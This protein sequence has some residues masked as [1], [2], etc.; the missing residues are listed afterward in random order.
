MNAILRFSAL[1]DIAAILPVL[2]AL[3]KKPIIITSPLGKEL[4]KDEFDRFI[5]LRSKS[6]I[7]LV[8]LILEIRQY[9]FKSIID[10][11]KNDRSKLILTLSSQSKS[12][13][14]NLKNNQKATSLF[15]EMASQLASLDK[16]DNNFV[17]KEKNYIV[18]NAGSSPEWLSK[19]LPNTKWKEIITM[20]YDRFHLPIKLT[21]DNTEISYLNK[22]IEENTSIPI[23]NLAGKTTIQELKQLLNNAYLTVSTDSASMHIS[24]AMKTPT[25]GIFGPTNWIKSAPFGP[26]STVVYDKIY[27][28]DSKPLRKNSKEIDNYF[29][30]IDISEALENISKYIK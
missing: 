27:F 6:A 8:K 25:I 18:L 28:Q 10:F 2:R 16:I 13:K 5:I 7:D 17:Q 4:L 30:N 12:Y 19:R 22:I 15:Y 3:K 9:K 20:L 26:W 21:G 23:E 11:Q 29:D 24:A 14:N 1:G